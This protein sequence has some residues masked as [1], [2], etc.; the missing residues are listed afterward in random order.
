MEGDI[1]FEVEEK[2]D[3]FNDKYNKSVDIEGVVDEGNQWHVWGRG[4]IFEGEDYKKWQMWISKEYSYIHFNGEYRNKIAVPGWFDWKP[5]HGHPDWYESHKDE[6]W[7]TIEEI[8]SLRD[9]ELIE[10]E[11]LKKVIEME[12]NDFLELMEE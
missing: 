7:E 10:E 3:K 2:G 5:Y 4:H 6:F 9:N 11:K 12:K 8:G 1:V